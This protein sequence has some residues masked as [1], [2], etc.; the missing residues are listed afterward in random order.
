MLV[1]GIVC[2]LT[3]AAIF[4]MLAVG[5]LCRCEDEAE[6]RIRRSPIEEV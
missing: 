2:A 5:W 1:F 6:V 4:G 3:S